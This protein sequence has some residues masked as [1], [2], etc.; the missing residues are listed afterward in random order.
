[1]RNYGEEGEGNV[2]AGNR[3]EGDILAGGCSIN[4]C[5]S[6]ASKDKPCAA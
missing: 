2:K 6:P 3:N 5:S 1:M 4:V